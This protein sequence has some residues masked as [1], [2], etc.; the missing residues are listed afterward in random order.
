MS[1]NSSGIRSFRVCKRAGPSFKSDFNLAPNRSAGDVA[2]HVGRGQAGSGSARPF[3]TLPAAADGGFNELSVVVADSS[4]L[5]SRLPPQSG[6]HSGAWVVV[7]TR[8]S[9]GF[10][11]RGLGVGFHT[12]LGEQ[13]C[14]PILAAVELFVL[15]AQFG[16]LAKKLLDERK[17]FFAAEFFDWALWCSCCLLGQYFQYTES[18]ILVQTFS[19]GNVRGAWASP[20][21]D[22]PRRSARSGF[23][24]LLKYDLGCAPCGKGFA[25]GHTSSEARAVK[26]CVS[27]FQT[28]SRAGTRV[29]K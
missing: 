23:G 8:R 13:L 14:L 5:C 27:C 29:Q 6:Q 22:F 17:E 21:A 11:A 19:V 7:A 26:W 20:S 3:A 15:R 24:P 4:P 9:V 10:A 1:A 28:K 12:L 16:V 18:R 2:E 25:I